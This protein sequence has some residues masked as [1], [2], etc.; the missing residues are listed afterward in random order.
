MVNHLSSYCYIEVDEYALETSFQTLE[1]A[2]ATFL[3]V[4]ESLEKV[5]ISFAYVKSTKTTI[6]NESP[7]GWGEVIDISMNKD[8]FS[9][10]QK[11]SAKEGA[12]VPTKDRMQCI[13]EVFLNAG[14]VYGDQ[15]NAIEEYIKDEDMSNLVYQCEETLTNWEAIEIPKVIPISK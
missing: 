13:Q 12:S 8:C 11:P 7:E 2:N 10:G 1:I 5:I 3:E 6:N 15:V 9:L 4:K 14:Y